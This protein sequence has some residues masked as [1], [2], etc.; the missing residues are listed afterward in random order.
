MLQAAAMSLV[1]VESHLFKHHEQEMQAWK[2]PS[3]HVFRHNGERGME[4]IGPS[5]YSVF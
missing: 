5:G 1:I 4:S 3:R 2:L